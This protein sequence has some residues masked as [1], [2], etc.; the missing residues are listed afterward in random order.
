MHFLRISQVGTWNLLSA[1]WC[2][3][4]FKEVAVYS[5]PS[6]LMLWIPNLGMMALCVYYTV[7][8]CKSRSVAG[9]EVQSFK[10][11]LWTWMSLSWI[12]FKTAYI[13]NGTWINPLFFL[14]LSLCLVLKEKSLVAHSITKNQE[15]NVCIH[16]LLTRCDSYSVLVIFGCS[17]TFWSWFLLPM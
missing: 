15:K 13:W 10:S 5:P 6:V 17:G 16:I 12:L 8:E 14:S 9:V 4:A 2:H 1:F 3:C 11:M 7:C